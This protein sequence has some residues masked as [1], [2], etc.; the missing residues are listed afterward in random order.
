MC[1]Y[2][3]WLSVWWKKLKAVEANKSKRMVF[4]YE[5]N[6]VWI[7]LFFL[8]GAKC[9]TQRCIASWLCLSSNSTFQICI[10]W[11]TTHASMIVCASNSWT[12]VSYI[13]SVFV[14]SWSTCPSR[15][16][17]HFWYTTMFVNSSQTSILVA[18]NCHHCVKTGVFLV[19]QPSKTLRNAVLWL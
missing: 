5:Q 3:I 7:R 13:F 14:Q 18:K 6:T 16:H 11:S 2:S 9:G 4:S 19:F 10:V 12:Q 1:V 17:L 8:S 15:S